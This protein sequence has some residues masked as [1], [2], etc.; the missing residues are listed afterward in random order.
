MSKTYM[1]P[2]LILIANLLLFEYKYEAIW[3]AKYEI[4]KIEVLDISVLIILWNVCMKVSMYN[5]NC[6]TSP[7]ILISISY[8]RYTH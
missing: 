2:I 3:N 1:F 7:Q 8:M 5:Q 4:G 6:V